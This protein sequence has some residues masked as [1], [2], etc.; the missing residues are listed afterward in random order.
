M[1][2]LVFQI[3]I[4]FD[5]EH[6]LQSLILHV[7]PCFTFVEHEFLNLDVVCDQFLIEPLKF[8][9]LFGEF[10]TSFISK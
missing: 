4:I 6:D 2:R 3:L 8:V 9:D 5:I 1:S 10:K 7:V